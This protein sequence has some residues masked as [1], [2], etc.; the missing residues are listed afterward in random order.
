M[1]WLREYIGTSQRDVDKLIDYLQDKSGTVALSVE[2]SEKHSRMNQCADWIRKYASRDKV[3]QMMTNQVWHHSDGGEYKI[4]KR[5][6]YRDYQDTQEVFAI[7]F[8]NQKAFWIDLL[9]GWIAETRLRAMAGDKKELKIAAQCERTLLDVITTHMGD[10]DADRY[11][12]LQVMPMMMAFLPDTKPKLP[13]NW[14]QEVQ[15]LIERKSRLM[16][17]NDGADSEEN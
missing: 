8:K 2:L 17:P 14:E 12:Q 9:I 13:D 3:V 7:D 15:M 1:N 11:K 4:D 10:A 6:A 16:L 5:T